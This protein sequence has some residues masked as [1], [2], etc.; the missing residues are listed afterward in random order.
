VTEAIGD[1]A[2]TMVLYVTHSV[3]S[4]DNVGDQTVTS[5]TTE[6]VTTD[7]TYDYGIE[8]NVAL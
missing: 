7:G 5:V 2:A 3:T 6:M 8:S 4:A 1:V